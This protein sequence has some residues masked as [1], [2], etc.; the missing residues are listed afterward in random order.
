MS[1]RHWRRS[2]RSKEEE[3]EEKL[4]AGLT[5]IGMGEGLWISRFRLAGETTVKFD[6]RVPNIL[7]RESSLGLRLNWDG[8][9]GYESRFFNSIARIS[10]GR[11]RGARSTTLRKYKPHPRKWFPRKDE[12]VPIGQVLRERPAHFASAR[13]S[14]S[15]PCSKTMSTGMPARERWSR[16]PWSCS[17]T[18]PS[19]RVRSFAAW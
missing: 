15:R 19:S 11:V 16:S 2:R 13:P 18:L 5:A 3:E 1:A 12:P 8:K 7:T 4:L 17:G 10:R 9:S 6:M 14:T